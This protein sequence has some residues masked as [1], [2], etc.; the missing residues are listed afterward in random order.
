MKEPFEV[1]LFSLII[2]L[3]KLQ[4]QSEGSMGLAFWDSVLSILLITIVIF[5][6]PCPQSSLLNI[7]RQF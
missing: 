4:A 3:S 5:T 1:S 2:R 7:L 6:I